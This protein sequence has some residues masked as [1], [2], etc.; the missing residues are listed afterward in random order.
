MVDVSWTTSAVEDEDIMLP[1]NFGM[2]LPVDAVTSR[3]SRMKRQLHHC[4]NLQTPV[5]L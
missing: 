3:P 4:R 5:D 1:P 2:R